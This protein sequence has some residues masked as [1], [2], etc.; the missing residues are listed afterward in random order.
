[1]RRLLK[2][3]TWLTLLGLLLS[4]CA[5]AAEPPAVP[6][7]A[8]PPPTSAPAAAPSAPKPAA[9]APTPKPAADQPASG[10]ILT[11]GIGGDPPSL[12]IHQEESSYTYA[13]TTATYNNLL[14]PDPKGWPDFKPVGSLATSWQVSPDGKV[15]TFS[16]VKGAKFHDGSTFTAEDAKFSL[17][18]IRN[19]QMGMTRSPRQ[20][21][22]T[23]VSSIDATDDSTLKIALKQ[24]QASFVPILATVFYSIM[25]KRLVMEKNNDMTKTVVGTGP[26]KFKN[27]TSGVSWELEKNPNY[28]VPGRPYLN[29]VKGYIIPD[30]FTKFA[31]FRTKNILWWGPS[32]PFMSASQARIIEEQ[33]SDKIAVQVQFHPAWYGVIF[34]VSQPPWNDARV[35]QAVS[36]TLDRPKMVATALEGA[37]IPGMSAQPMGMWALPEEEMQKVPGYAKPDIEAA[38]KLLAEA[39]FPSGFKSENTVRG[40]K[41]HQDV[42]VLLKNAAATVGI[43]LDLKVA[44]TAVY[45]NALFRKAF[46]TAVGGTSAKLDD[47]DLTLGDYYVTGSAR[48]WAGYSNRYFDELYQKQSATAD[49]TERRKLVWEMQRILLK[50]VPIAIAYWVKIP[51]AWWKEVKGFVVPVGVENAFGYEDIWLAK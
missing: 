26:F 18:R 19:P 25:P 4:G 28:F 35:R 29:G 38:R 20:Q 8:A 23:V 5:P 31:A 48:N 39:G 22:L 24:P 43:E 44:E 32:V 2:L 16:L 10:G 42:G 13:F 21:Q 50:D 36:L 15:V 11:V 12:D 9:P 45:T 47:P 1:M 14:K 30:L 34:N 33:L 7:A 40:V 41:A 51:Y 37:G 17:D 27:Y 49:P 3:V 46:S 6:K